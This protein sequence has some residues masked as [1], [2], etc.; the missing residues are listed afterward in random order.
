MESGEEGEM[1]DFA[2]GSAAVLGLMKRSVASQTVGL[3]EW[4]VFVGRGAE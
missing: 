2:G 4:D 3:R 1:L